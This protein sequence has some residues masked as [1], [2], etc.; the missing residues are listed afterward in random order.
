M[1]YLDRQRD[2]YHE[3]LKLIDK[4]ISKGKGIKSLRKSIAKRINKLEYLIEH[5]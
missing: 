3:V 2:Q 1:S 5:R 4:K